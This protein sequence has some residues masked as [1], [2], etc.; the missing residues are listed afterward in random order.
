V[1]PILNDSKLDRS[2]YLFGDVLFLCDC[3]NYGISVSLLAQAKN[4]DISAH[5]QDSSLVS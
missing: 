1:A 5:V 4:M 3:Y 2:T